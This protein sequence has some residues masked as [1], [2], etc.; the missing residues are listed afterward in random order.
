MASGVPVIAADATAI[1]EVVGDAGVLC[2][3]DDPDAFAAAMREVLEQPATA[4][5]MKAAGLER[6]RQF[7]WARCA[8]LTHEGFELAIKTYENRSAD[9]GRA[10]PSTVS[11]WR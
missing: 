3:P 5:A 10:V 7:S 2:D 8:R 6:A 1:P 11:R 4:A 9:V